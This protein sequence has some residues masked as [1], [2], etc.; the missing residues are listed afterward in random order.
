MNSPLTSFYKDIA[1]DENTRRWIFIQCFSIAVL[2]LLPLL[3]FAYYLKTLDEI[4]I[5]KS[6]LEFISFSVVA[7]IL[8]SAYYYTYKCFNEDKFYFFI[9]LGWIANAAYLIPAGF[10][11]KPEISNITYQNFQN[12][13]FIFSFVSTVY[14]FI[15]WLYGVKNKP[16]RIK[17][18]AGIVI[19]MTGI[20]VDLYYIPTVIQNLQS[21]AYV[22]LCFSVVNFIVIWLVGLSFETHIRV[23]NI[24]VNPVT[25][26]ITFFTYATLQF[27]GPFIPHWGKKSPEN[28]LWLPPLIFIVAQIVK[29]VNAISIMGVIQK[30]NARREMS[31]EDGVRETERKLREQGL[32]LEAQESKLKAEEEKLERERQYIALG[33]LAASIKHDVNTPLATMS[34]DIGAL[35]ERFQHDKTTI[36]RLEKLQE[37][38]KR[39]RAIVK[40]VDYFRGDREFY[41]RDDFM[42]K[43]SMLEIVNRAVRLVKNEIEALKIENPRSRI[44]IKGRDVWVRANIPMLEQVVVNVIKN[45]LEAI[46]EAERE[47]GLIDINVGKVE[48]TDTDYSHWVKVEIADNGCGIPKENIEKLTTMFT[49]RS[50]K[51]PNSGI[52][53]FIGEKILDIHDGRIEF[54]SSV[55]DWTKVTLL[56]PEWDV[57]RKKAAET[58]P[59]EIDSNDDELSP[60][61]E[62][63]ENLQSTEKPSH[64]SM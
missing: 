64:V 47:R 38:M 50:H 7:A 10:K 36:A 28:F 16:N 56:L 53:L 37:S 12:G 21:Q 39:I 9:F 35:K 6:H 3:V 57:S 49:T 55:G 59:L 8:A 61:D 23:Q 31:I 51:K 30:T 42:E 18:Y 25:I 62:G 11:T 24:H 44:R 2:I 45:G 27:F 40:V 13:I 63:A 54:E 22:H 60:G 52:G 14:L 29:L 19:L 1:Q 17:F 33:K 43:A 26:Q 46:E 4:Y 58:S 32:E 41:N 34:F 5:D 15:A 48:L 20:S